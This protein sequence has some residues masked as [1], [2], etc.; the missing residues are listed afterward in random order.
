MIGLP[1]ATR[2]WRPAG[3]TDMRKGFDSLA[4]N[5]R[6]PPLERRLSSDGLARSVKLV[7]GVGFEPT[8]LQ[9]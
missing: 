3:V 5:A 1:A 6:K 4:V 8:T 9:V 7:A 2:V